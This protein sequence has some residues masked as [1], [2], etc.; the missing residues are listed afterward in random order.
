V[1]PGTRSTA[2]QTLRNRS[3]LRPVSSMLVA[4][5]DLVALT[6][7][8]Q[9]SKVAQQLAT[10]GIRFVRGADNWPRVLQAELDR[11]LLGANEH[12]NRTQPDIDALR[13]WQEH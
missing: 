7:R 2:T 1:G 8:K 11:V 5:E 13:A 12:T 3:G 4:R 9:P 10:M 6:G